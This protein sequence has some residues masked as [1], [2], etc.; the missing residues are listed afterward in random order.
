MLKIGLFRK[1]KKKKCEQAADPLMHKLF[2]RMEENM[3]NH[4]PVPCKIK[5]TGRVAFLSTAPFFHFVLQSR[6]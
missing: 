6:G 1:Y 4:H 5:S 2:A 3:K